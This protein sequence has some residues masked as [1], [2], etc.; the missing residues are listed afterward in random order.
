MTTLRKLFRTTLLSACL[1][2][3][4]SATVTAADAPPAWTD[5]PPAISRLLEDGDRAERARMPFLAA[6]H[7]CQA[8]RH[9]NTEAQYRLGRMYM[10]GEGVARDRAI[11]ATLLGIAARQGHERAEKL[12]A[13]GSAQD[14][15]PDCIENGNA[16]LLAGNEAVPHTVVTRFV[17]DLPQAKRRHAEMVKRLAP[18]FAVDPRL[19]LAIVR[20]ESN[21]NADARS[22]KNAQGLMQLIPETAARFGVRDAFDPEQNVRGGLAYLR[23]LLN[24]F[25]G[26]V[27][28]ASAAYNA[29]EGAVARHGGVP[30]YAETREYVRRILAFYRSPQHVAPDAAAPTAAVNVAA[31]SRS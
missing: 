13:G 4:W 31:R 27:A 30:P 23:W 24:R 16:A 9:G 28:L 18:R 12:L 22:P 17:Q 15:L 29:G 14:R 8:A 6:T 19:A 11:G 1:L 10:K 26:D 21:F 25:D 7:Y 20:A 3:G 5:E 2:T